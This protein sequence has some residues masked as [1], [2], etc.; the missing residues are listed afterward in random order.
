MNDEWLN[1]LPFSRS[2]NHSLSTQ[3]GFDQNL[4]FGDV[5]LSFTW[6]GCNQSSESA[7]KVKSPRLVPTKNK[8]ATQFVPHVQN[9]FVFAGH[10]LIS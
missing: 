1:F 4:C 6:S 8:F 10:P 7:K 3:S 5:L 9:S 2:S